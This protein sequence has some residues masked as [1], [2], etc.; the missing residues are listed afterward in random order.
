MESPI[1]DISPEMLLFQAINIFILFLI[2]RR[3]LYQPLT[4]LMH[5]RTQEIEQGLEEAKKNRERAQQLQEEYDSEIQKARREA[6][7]II[8]KAS[9]QKDEIIKEGKEETQK[10]TEKMLN[11]AKKE[12]EIERERAFEALRQ[13]IVFFS[14]NIAERIIA[15]EIDPEAQKEMVN[16]YLEEVGRE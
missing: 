6:R 16:R 9:R 14:V 12:I 10:Q 7:E 13:D 3:F 1:I 11:E 4:N 15:K 8:E 2:L 5:N